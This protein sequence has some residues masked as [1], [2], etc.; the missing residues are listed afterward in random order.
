MAVDAAE[1]H[2]AYANDPAVTRYLGWPRHQTIADT[3]A[4]IQFCEQ[5]WSENGVGAYLVFAKD[6]TQLLGST[7]LELEPNQQAATGYVLRRSAWGKG[8]ATEALQAMVALAQNLQLND[9]YALCHTEHRASSRV[10]EKCGFALQATLPAHTEF[11]NLAPGEELDVLR[12]NL[13]LQGAADQS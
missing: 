2:A 11:P 6:T 9:V 13:H 7:G 3:D 4:F 5:S 8:Y 1:I 10:L 12:Y